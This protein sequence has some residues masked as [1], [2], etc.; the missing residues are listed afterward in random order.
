[1]RRVLSS[2]FL[3]LLLVGAQH[4]LLV[5]DIGHGLGQVP[6]AASRA[7]AAGTAQGARVAGMV[8]AGPSQGARRSGTADAGSYCEKCFQFANVAAALAGAVPLPAP[9]VAGVESARA[10]LA[11]AI[12]ADAPQTRSRGPPALL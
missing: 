3:A 6:G 8:H 10:L 12:A 4:A 5:H 7:V 1:M 9:L 11:A 2:F